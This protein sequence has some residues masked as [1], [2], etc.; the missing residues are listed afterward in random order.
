[1]LVKS[2]EANMRKLA[3]LLGRDL[4]YLWGAC[5]C[6]PNGDKKVFLNTGRAFLRAL[7]KDL[8]FAEYKVSVNPGGIAVSGDCSLIGMWADSGLYV[9]LSQPCC[10]RENVL[11]Y[12]TVCH[13]KDYSGG[14]NQYIT[15]RE[16]ESLSYGQFLDRLA[17]GICHERAA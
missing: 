3:R 5:E 9:Q 17:D 4:S 8:I 1:M 14:R 16:L 7:A 6:G 11:L 13:I 15:R 10:Q 12:R 2:Q